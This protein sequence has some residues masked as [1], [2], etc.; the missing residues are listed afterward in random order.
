MGCMSHGHIA[1]FLTR[2]KRI[3]D[4]SGRGAQHQRQSNIKNVKQFSSPIDPRVNLSDLKKNASG[5]RRLLWFRVTLEISPNF[6][7]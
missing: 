4:D 3:R 2:V 5:S 6:Q 7:A 1:I